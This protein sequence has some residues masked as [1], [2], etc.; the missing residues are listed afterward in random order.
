MTGVLWRGRDGMH[1]LPSNNIWPGGLCR[2]EKL[3][4]TARSLTVSALVL[5]SR[6]ANFYHNLVL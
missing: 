2:K 5:Q 6:K 1:Y 3:L 4:L